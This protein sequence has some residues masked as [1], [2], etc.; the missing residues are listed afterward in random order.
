MN[1]A[2]DIEVWRLGLA[3][4]LFGIVFFIV[5][6]KRLKLEK[7]LINSVIRMTLQLTFLGFALKSLFRI[8]LWTVI[9]GIFFIMVFFAARTIIKRSGIAFPGITRLLFF[10]ILL[11]AGSVLMFFIHVVVHN[12]PWYEPRYFIPLAGMIIGNSMNGSALAL[13]R[14]YEDI[15]QR[16]REIETWVSFGA[17]A[18]EAALEPFRKAYRSAL[19]PTLT[20]MT[21]MG[22]VFIPGMMTGQILGGSPPLT[23]I[24]YQMAIM[25]AILTSVA[26]TCFLI[27]SL[28]FRRLFNKY[29]LV[30][31]DIFDA[32]KP[33]HQ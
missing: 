30:N 19:V 29:H 14:F 26:L 13:E 3:Y 15:K 33:S 27:L 16:R 1:G 32:G 31:E 24:K 18:E 10:S 5:W 6:W 12:Q 23:A 17:T 25:A 21:G 9:T 11:G 22:I 28:E 2:L 8:E 4:L 7:D 20:S